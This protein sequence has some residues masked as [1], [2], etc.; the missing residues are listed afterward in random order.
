MVLFQSAGVDGLPWVYL[1]YSAVSY[2]T[3]NTESLGLFQFTKA[4]HCFCKA[5]L[6]MLDRFESGYQGPFILISDSIL[7]LF[8]ISLHFQSSLEG[9]NISRSF[10]IFIY[11]L[12]EVIKQKHRFPVDFYAEGRASCIIIAYRLVTDRSTTGLGCSRQQSTAKY[13]KY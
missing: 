2:L 7:L 6:C 3:L 10:H 4:Q 11:F 13:L 9:R 8:L 1:I 12:P 5:C